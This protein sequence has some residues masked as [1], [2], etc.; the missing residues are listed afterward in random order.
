MRGFCRVA[1]L[2]NLS[3]HAAF[4][5]MRS[6]NCFSPEDGDRDTLFACAAYP[7]RPLAESLRARRCLGR[8]FARADM[9]LVV[10]GP[11]ESGGFFRFAGDFFFTPSIQVFSF[12]L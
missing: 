11:F 3:R 6:A 4:L 7:T 5:R 10:S 2:G 12:S 1:P 8:P 9:K